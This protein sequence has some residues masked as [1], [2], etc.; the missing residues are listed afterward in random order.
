MKRVKLGPPILGLLGLPDELLGRCLVASLAHHAGGLRRLQVYARL[1]H[2][3]RRFWD[4]VRTKTPDVWETAYIWCSML[5][6]EGLT[7]FTRFISDLPGVRVKRV[8]A[9]VWY[10]ESLL[11]LCDILEGFA[12][13][14]ETL[15]LQF[16]HFGDVIP[17][18][19]RLGVILEGLRAIKKL[20]IDA[21]GSL[22]VPPMRT[23]EKMVVQLPENMPVTAAARVVGVQPEL[24]E[25]VISGRGWKCED[26]GCSPFAVSFWDGVPALT[27]LTVRVGVV[28][29]DRLFEGKPM[30]VCRSLK[31]LHINMYITQRTFE[32]ARYFPNL[33]ELILD[34][35]TPL[36][37]QQKFVSGTKH[38]PLLPHLKAATFANIFLGE[39]GESLKALRGLTYLSLLKCRITSLHGLASLE[40][41]RGLFVD[42]TCGGY[43]HSLSGLSGAHKH[44]SELSIVGPLRDASAL[45]NVAPTLENVQLSGCGD[46]M[47]RG[48]PLPELLENGKLE[49]VHLS[50]TACR[51][52]AGG[53]S[54]PTLKNVCIDGRARTDAEE[55]GVG[56]LL[57]M[58]DPHVAECVT[59]PGREEAAGL[60]FAYEY[61]HAARMLLYHN[62]NDLRMYKKDM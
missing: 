44:L 58:I 4:V 15:A 1:Q 2:V 55:W 28:T 7:N 42:E 57:S 56:N 24:K 19:P 8:L 30:D 16:D 18:P 53:V 39:G 60:K 47:V 9:D 14:V 11:S 23:L 50:P 43:L 54:A 49:N 32:F 5:S 17:L 33:E 6:P 20:S 38:I 35:G 61:P 3:N 26:G 45:R 31:S 59:W 62:P 52:F 25:L 37:N 34:A 36:A 21:P 22:Q 10:P 41:L 27:S 13:S 51:E 46:V 29:I 40:N 12:T 48:V